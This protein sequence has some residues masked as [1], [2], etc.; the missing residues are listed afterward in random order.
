MLCKL[1]AVLLLT[2]SCLLAL[3]DAP[4]P[5]PVEPK[6]PIRY[7]QFYDRPARVT[8]AAELT[9]N[10]FDTAQTCNNLAHGG[11]EDALPIKSCAG[12]VGIQ[13]GIMAA[14]EGLAYFLHRTHHYKL[15][16]IPRYYVIGANARGLIYSK[17]H[18]AF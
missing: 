12:M 7:H 8:L 3:P 17:A 6:P 16:R 9:L 5:K 13:L 2:P 10:A 1:L 4:L 18:G 15:E 14:G 11:H